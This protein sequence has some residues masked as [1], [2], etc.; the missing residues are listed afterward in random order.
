MSGHR[1]RYDLEVADYLQLMPDPGSGK[2]IPSAFGML[3]LTIGSGS[4][5]NT[6]PDP[7]RAGLSLTI[8]VATQGGG[9]RAITAATAINQT[10]NTVMTFNDARDV[11]QLTAIYG[12]IT[13]GG[14]PKVHW[15][16]DFNDGVALS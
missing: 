7:P 12:G 11:I 2:A 5:T 3:V 6:L 15:E 16:V 9:T 8:S 1:Q 14:T 4:E 13:S 10:G